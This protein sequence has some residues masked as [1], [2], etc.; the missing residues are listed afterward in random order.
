MMSINFSIGQEAQIAE[1]QLEL[2]IELL[3]DADKTDVKF[4]V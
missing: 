4:L 3:G 2:T 1:F